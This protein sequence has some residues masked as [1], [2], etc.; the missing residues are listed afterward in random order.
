M[1]MERIAL[2]YLRATFVTLL[3]LGG[4]TFSNAAEPFARIKSVRIENTNVV[5]EAE[6]S[7][8]FTKATLEEKV[9]KIMQKLATTA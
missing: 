7:I 9:A 4:I 1:K 8:G 6:A 3:A 5:V 2:F